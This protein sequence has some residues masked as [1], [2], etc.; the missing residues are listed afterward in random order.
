MFHVQFHEV[1]FERYLHLC[2]IVIV[3]IEWRLFVNNRGMALVEF[4]D[5]TGKYLAFTLCVLPINQP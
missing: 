3:A 5:T 4:V 2:F 1:I